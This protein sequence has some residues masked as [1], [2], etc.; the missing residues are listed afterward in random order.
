MKVFICWSGTV[1]ERIGQEIRS[2]IPSVIQSVEPYFTPSDT[3]K[4]TQWLPEITKHLVDSKV[5]I[6]CVTR[7]NIHRDWLLFEAGALSKQLGKAHV[8]PIL[9]GIK[10]T[11]LAGP[12]KQ[13]QAT[14]FEKAEF[15][16]LVNV[17]NGCLGDS[18][19]APKTLEIVFEKWW[20]DLKDNVDG[21]L[22]SAA[23]TMPSEP[24]RSDREILEELLELTRQRSAIAR[25]ARRRVVSSEVM[26]A[27]INTYISLHNQQANGEDGYQEALDVLKNLRQPIVDILRHTERS[28]ELSELYE[29]FAELSYKTSSSEGSIDDDEIPF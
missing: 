14:G 16:K 23:G 6:I 7:E 19:L 15:Q 25:R 1:S 24:I 21:I 13:F 27:M 8:C 2:W 20:P 11:D 9:F 10:H 5:G 12:L 28:D 26:V 3:D 18:K 4:G 22:N 29:Q 17:I